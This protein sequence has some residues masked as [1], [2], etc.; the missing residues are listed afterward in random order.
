M[1]RIVRFH[2]FGDAPVLRIEEVPDQPPAADEV[3]LAV[4]AIGLNRSEV[5]FRQG[6]YPLQRAQFPSR[7]GYEAAGVV[8]AVGDRV[9]GVKVGDHVGTVPAFNLSR[10]GVYGEVATVPGSAVALSPP[11]LN[12]A[13]RA[14]L[15]AA[16]AT[17]YGGLI[18]VGRIDSTSRVVIPAAS[19]SVGIAAIQI[20]RAE[21]A[22]AIALTRTAAK[23]EALLALGAHHVVVTD[24][25]DPV[26][27]IR[28]VTDG[29]G[30]TLAFDPVV[31]PLFEQLARASAPGA[32]LVVYGGLDQR[33]AVFPRG[34]VLGKNLWVRGYTVFPT[35]SDP[36]TFRRAQDYIW[37][38]V[39]R[40]T[41]NP[42][43]ARE[44]HGL[45]QIGAAQ[46][47]MESNAQIGKIV[48]SVTG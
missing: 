4:E 29:A 38:G 28:D 13:Q 42:V 25:E 14:A 3:Q 46:D 31:G 40:G 44:F 15:W 30:L 45:E 10:Y 37:G 8:T 21:G 36:A 5:L 47:Y 11:G 16:Y 34:P 23:R 32:T 6:H 43:V 12:A 9:T 1:A 20:C 22:Q 35:V 2:E 26:E 24:E 48:V 18:D 7:I 41:L 19:S 39:H 27:R 17:A 33:D